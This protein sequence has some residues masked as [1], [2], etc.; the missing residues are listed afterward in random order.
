M[1]LTLLVIGRNETTLQSFDRENI[2][3]SDL[4]LVSNLRQEPLSKIANRYLL[5]SRDIFGL[6]HADAWFGSGSLEIFTKIAMEGKVC[7]IVGKGLDM[8]YYQCD[9]NPGEVSTLDGCSIFF[10][11][12]SKLKF[13]ELLFDGFHCHVEDLCLQAKKIGMEVIVPPANASHGSSEVK[14]KG[15]L[16]DYWRYRGL[17][18]KKWSGVKFATT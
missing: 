17:L 16:Q 1:Q 18:G 14:G 13:D 3:D 15:W 8:V 10:P 6:C 12:K 5:N 9:K 7:G 11:T 4:V 2:G